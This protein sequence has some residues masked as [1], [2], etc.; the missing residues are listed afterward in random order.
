M[1]KLSTIGRALAILLLALF[2]SSR[3]IAQE[4]TVTTDV[5][6]EQAPAGSFVVIAVVLDHMP[7]WHSWPSV[8]QDVLAPEIA[9]FAI[10]TEISITETPTQVAAVYAVQWPEPHDSPVSNPMGDPPTVNALTYSG[11][12]VAYIPVKIADDAT[13]TFTIPVKVSY[14]ACD[15][16]I[17][18]MPVDLD[19]D[20]AVTVGDLAGDKLVTADFQNFDA[21]VFDVAPPPARNS[22]SSAT[23]GSGKGPLGI[24]LLIL[25][26]ALGGF[27]LNLTPCVLPVIPLKVMAMSAHADTPGKTLY[28]GLWMAAGVV[29]F[30]FGIG[31]PGAI[32]AGTFD[33][34][35]IFGI[36][37]ITLAIGLIIAAMAVGIMGA[38]NINL[39][40][41]A[42]MFNPKADTA[43]GSFL[44]GIMTG[45]LG[46]PCFGF[47][48]GALLAVAATLPAV[49]VLTMFTAIGAGMASPYLVLAI[50]PG[51]VDKI[52]RTGPASELIK[53]IMGLLLLAAATFFI[54]AA[55]LAFVSGS[56]SMSL[57]MPWWG[58]EIHVW[59]I[60]L[61]GIAAGGWL[62]VR[63]FQITK[64]G[65]RRIVFSLV[66]LVIAGFATT[67]AANSTYEG[68]HN[69]WT[70]Y[71]QVA[72][73]Q[74]IANDQIVV[75]DFTAAWCINCQFLEATILNASPVKG[76]LLES[77]VIPLVA[78]LTGSKA[79]G[80]KK[81]KEMGRVGIPYLAIFIGDADKPFWEANRYTSKQVMDAIKRAEE[82][83]GI[84]ET[85]A[86][87]D[88][89]GG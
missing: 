58:K 87:A 40:Q 29:A 10:R 5:S 11:R 12:A 7:G 75:V 26:S 82:S 60:G 69:F 24:I 33:P 23:T 70:P 2:S 47:V 45:V 14:Q 25:G 50:K 16:S 19:F 17:C 48:A 51:W 74:A 37:W 86:L 15:D 13:G 67:Y 66:A 72:L 73:D 88:S 81:L 77:H 8:D 43:T 79:V 84:V 68:Y 49:I 80:K 31:V 78:D 41:K 55:V 59:I 1:T 4:V 54:G 21:A 65:A 71:S 42:Y 89:E 56:V 38:F 83:L 76:K 46:L 64:S 39:P 35:S 18:L 36:W 63:T 6:A 85:A 28:L 53:Q 22:T 52:P 27:V 57:A 44:F 3:S 61:F 30:W 34:S 20:V 32:F 9:E 62:A